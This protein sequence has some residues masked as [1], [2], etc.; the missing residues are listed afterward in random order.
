M[1]K[2]DH[3]QNSRK[4]RP[5]AWKPRVWNTQGLLPQGSLGLVPTGHSGRPSARVVD[6][7]AG[8][9]CLQHDAARSSSSKLISERMFKE[10]KHVLFDEE[11]FQTA[12]TVCQ[13]YHPLGQL[14]VSVCLVLG[15]TM[16]NGSCAW[17]RVFI[18]FR[19][20]VFT[21]QTSCVHESRSR[22]V[23]SVCT[24]GQCTQ[25][26]D[27]GRNNAEHVGC[28]SKSPCPFLSRLS[29]MVAAGG[30]ARCQSVSRR[31]QIFSAMSTILTL[32]SLSSPRCWR[33]L[34]N[35]RAFVGMW[36][37]PCRA[38]LVLCVMWLGPALH[39]QSPMI[40]AGC[41][42]GQSRGGALQR[43]QHPSYVLRSCSAGERSLP[44]QGMAGRRRQA[45][46]GSGRRAIVGG[47]HGDGQQ[48]RSKRSEMK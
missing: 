18:S 48:S 27:C 2:S 10:Q 43:Q 8:S 45:L 16:Q 30:A 23:C 7:P 5:G 29:P 17:V 41:G 24:V 9:M 3:A 39:G 44:L 31:F 22:I 36:S 35:A 46:R 38:C 1:V 6:F 42:A 33:C 19:L 21:V 12:C 11:L 13:L 14:S 47:A 40:A 15:V 32:S 37:P 34:I 28:L 25:W 20:L 26:L 4:K